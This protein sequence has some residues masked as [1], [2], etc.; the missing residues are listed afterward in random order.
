MFNKAH[1]AEKVIASTTISSYGIIRSFLFNQIMNSGWYLGMVHVLFPNLVTD[2]LIYKGLKR[3]GPCHTVKIVLN[4]L[5]D[6]FGPCALS[7]R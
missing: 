6:I 4:F 5:H 1:Y 3:M 2:L 7:S